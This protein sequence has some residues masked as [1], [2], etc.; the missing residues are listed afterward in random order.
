MAES[1]QSFA[2]PALEATIVELEEHGAKR[3]LLLR[4]DAE[5]RPLIENL[6]GT[7]A[8]SAG[9]APWVGLE[10]LS[11]D[12]RQFSDSGVVGVAESPT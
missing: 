5:G 11:F 9:R 12:Y 10:G 3:V 6:S 1:F 4:P 8:A 7:L 2:N